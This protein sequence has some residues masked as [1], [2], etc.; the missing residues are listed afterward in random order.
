MET[1]KMKFKLKK[2]VIGD[3]IKK[4]LKKKKPIFENFP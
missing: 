4:R 3:Q 1:I 2:Y